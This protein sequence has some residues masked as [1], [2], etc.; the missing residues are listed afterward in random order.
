MRVQ[1]I[2]LRNIIDM[3]LGDRSLQ[4]KINYIAL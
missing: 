1:S 3:G 2:G 4:G